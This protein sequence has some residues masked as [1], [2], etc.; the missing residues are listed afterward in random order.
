MMN[1]LME[2]F[3]NQ[4]NEFLPFLIFENNDVVTQHWGFLPINNYDVDELFGDLEKFFQ[5]HMDNNRFGRGK[6]IET[7]QFI[8]VLRYTTRKN[9]NVFEN[10][11]RQRRNETSEFN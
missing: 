11:E 1:E 5:K 8:A 3:N 2:E 4:W 9:T 10:S 6:Y 7:R